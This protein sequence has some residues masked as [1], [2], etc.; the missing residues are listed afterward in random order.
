MKTNA[1]K[2]EPRND[3]FTMQD[4]RDTRDARD[5]RDTRDARDRFRNRRQEEPRSGNAF[6]VTKRVKEK[7]LN[8]NTENFPELTAKVETQTTEENAEINYASA[9]NKVK[10]KDNANALQAEK[11]PP[12][13]VRISLDSNR[14][15][16]YEYGEQTYKSMDDMTL[17]E[18]MNYAIELMKKRWIRHKENY[19]ELYGEDAYEKYYG[20]YSY[21]DY[22][23]ELDSEE[24]DY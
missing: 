3:R 19:I 23:P 21:T 20:A 9:L 12:G 10:E 8:F 16:N 6:G 15:F 4:T 13:W 11:V 2:S 14:K 24:L 5:A 7:E 17:N 18:E 1:F 22:E